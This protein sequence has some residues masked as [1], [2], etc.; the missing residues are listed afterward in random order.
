MQ[1]TKI[2]I[3]VEE[4]LEEIRPFLQKDGGDIILISVQE[5]TAKVQ[6]TGIC[7]SCDKSIMTLASISA[8]VMEKVS[9]IKE[10]VE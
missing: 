7:S 1:Q 4:A 2:F 5:G 3:K 9:E 10:V 6:F 8:I